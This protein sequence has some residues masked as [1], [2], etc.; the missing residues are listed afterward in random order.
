V[1][2]GKARLL[3]R[4]GPVARD[5]RLDS[6]GDGAFRAMN[7]RGVPLARVLERIAAA[8]KAGFGRSSSSPAL[9]V[10]A[11]R[12]LR[13]VLTVCHSAATGIYDLPDRTVPELP[14]DGVALA[15][16]RPGDGCGTAERLPTY[17]WPEPY[18]V[19]A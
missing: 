3:R 15:S 11:L 6:L 19:A 10:D 16:A 4:G 9:A 8:H 5:D 2:V 7:D 18:G 14:A 13:D 12:M 17:D 1:L